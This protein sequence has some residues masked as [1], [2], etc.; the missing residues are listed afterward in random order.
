MPASPTAAASP[1]RIVRRD[2][3]RPE[4]VRLI[5]ADRRLVRRRHAGRRAA[6]RRLRLAA[7]SALRERRIAYKTGTS[8]GF[9]DAWAA[10]YSANWT[11][12]VWVGHADGTPRPGPARPARG[13]AD[14]VQGVRP[15]ARRGQSRRRRRRPTCC[16][17]PRHRE[18]PPR[19]RTPGAGDGAEPTARRASPI[20]RPMRRIELRRARG[21]AARRHG[22]QRQPALAGRRPAARRHQMDARR[23]RRGARR[24]GRR[25]RPF[26]AP[27]PCG[28]SSGPD[29]QR[30]PSLSD[31]PKS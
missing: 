4:P 15:P 5:G 22:R 16:A 25:C 1:R 24:R 21:G 30:C 7:A 23:R 29:R 31:R 20:R 18:L 10:G 3:P 27:S 11:V 6:A 19:M 17:S 8:A 2:R 14:H 26:D 28:S 13:A 9:R 12:V